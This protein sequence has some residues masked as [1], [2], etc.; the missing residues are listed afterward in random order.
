[1]S[2]SIDANILLYASDT[3]S[4]Y[5]E[6]A[7]AFLAEKAAGPDVFYLAWPTIMSYLRMATH[8][9]IFKAPL[10]PDEAMR[11]VQQ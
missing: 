4:P 1:M 10:S 6:R 7:G 11:N 2:F 5:A 8:A 3:Q 9:G